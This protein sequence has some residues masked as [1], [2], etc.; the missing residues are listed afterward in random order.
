MAKAVSDAKSELIGDATTNGNT[1]GKLEDKIDSAISTAAAAHTVVNAKANG[2]VKVTV[3][4]SS[5]NTHD[6]VT[7]TENDIASADVL[8]AEVAARK[9]VSGQTGATYA[10]N[11]SANYINTATSLND[12]DVKLDAAIKAVE[13]MLLWYEEDTAN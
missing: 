2:H 3:A 12:A 10:A 6:V 7:I 13:N 11:D 4:K 8:T 1:L 5:D 9:A